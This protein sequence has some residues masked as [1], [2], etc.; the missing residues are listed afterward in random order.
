MDTGRSVVG[1]HD[2]SENLFRLGDGSRSRIWDVDIFLS[3]DLRLLLVEIFRGL[4]ACPLLLLAMLRGVVA[5]KRL[6]QSDAERVFPF[7][8]LVNKVTCVAPD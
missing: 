5:L 3:D 8:E 6:S 4:E 7:S 2:G 1:R